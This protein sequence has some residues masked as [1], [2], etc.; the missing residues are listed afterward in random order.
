MTSIYG[1]SGMMVAVGNE[2]SSFSVYLSMCNELHESR[3][4]VNKND[5]VISPYR[6]HLTHYKHSKRVIGESRKHKG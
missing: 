2:G 3:T 6:T 5:R 4:L 1:K